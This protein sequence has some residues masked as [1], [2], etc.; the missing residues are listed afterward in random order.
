MKRDSEFP[1]EDPS[2]GE[3]RFDEAA[4]Q[5]ILRRAAEEQTR[6]E[7]HDTASFSLEQLE[8]IATEAGISPEAVRAAAREHET[9]VA[10][11]EGDRGWL[12]GLKARM[13]AAWSSRFKNAILATAGLALFALVV[14][15]VGVGP[16]VFTL[17]AAIL[18]LVLLLILLGLGP[19]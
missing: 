18:I 19:V 1:A 12:A 10:L 15:V 5:R 7:S 13:P 4:A 6:R 11:A 17:S 16:V 8:E 14:A 9:S 2:E 3:K